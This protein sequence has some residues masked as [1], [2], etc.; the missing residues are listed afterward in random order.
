MKEDTGRQVTQE[1]SVP[2]AATVRLAGYEAEGS[3]DFIRVFTRAYV[4]LPRIPQLR[5]DIAAGSGPLTLRFDA[6]ESGGVLTIDGREFDAPYFWLH[7]HT[8]RIR[9]N[10]GAVVSNWRTAAG[11]L[12]A[13]VIYHRT[14]R[15][16]TSVFFREGP[17]EGGT[18]TWN[19]TVSAADRP[20]LVKT[21]N[22]AIGV[23][24]GVF[25]EARYDSDHDGLRLYVVPHFPA[26]FTSVPATGDYTSAGAGVVSPRPGWL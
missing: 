3:P 20:G 13:G 15:S 14:N 4:S 19:L 6:S 10:S 17:L 16:G 7:H 25:L 22:D 21:L 23:Q 2:G 26:R 5:D 1:V 9:T 8:L 18:A 24:D 12:P 11:G